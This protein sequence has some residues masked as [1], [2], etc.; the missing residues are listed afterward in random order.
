MSTHRRK[1]PSEPDPLQTL[2]IEDVARLLGVDAKTIRRL[3]V[4]GELRAT[5]V[6]KQIRFKRA[7]VND[8]LE[9]SDR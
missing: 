5:K 2:N 9:R 8:F 6:G 3:M 7:W 1:P 4:R